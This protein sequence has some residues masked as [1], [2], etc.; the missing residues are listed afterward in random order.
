MLSR[1]FLVA[2]IVL[3]SGCS[4]L[5]KNSDIDEKKNTRIAEINIQLGVAYLQQGDVQRAKQKLLYA[6]QTAPT[7]PEAWYSMAY[8]HEVTGHKD[9][10]KIEYLKAI[11]IIPNRGDVHNNY[12]T[13]LCRNGNYLESIQE[14]VN[15]AKD[16][17]YL[18]M[19]SAYENAGLCA[20]KIPDTKLAIK[21]FSQALQGDPN[22]EV[23][24][25][26]LKKLGYS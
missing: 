15:A 25:T 21:Y 12:G 22:R 4:S 5:Q 9:E 11:A 13:F 17:E 26:E 20:L 14:F 23:S 7:L 3:L 6:L 1:Y 8:F 19:P 10:A 2:F 18:E 16:P 24:I